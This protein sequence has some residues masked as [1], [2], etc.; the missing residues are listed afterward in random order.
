MNQVII[1]SLLDVLAI[2]LVCLMTVRGYLRG[3]SGE[4]AQLVSLGVAFFLGI[5]YFTP[6]ANWMV[7]HTRLNLESARVVGFV[8]TVLSAFLVMHVL[9]RLLGVFMKIVFEDKFD[10]VGG[11]VAGFLR[12]CVLLIIVFLAMNLWPHPYLNRKFGTESVIGSFLMR[13]L[14]SLCSHAGAAEPLAAEE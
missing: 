4:L 6:I 7:I 12:G 11:L 3:L 9:R 13:S 8:A 14:S 2:S 5:R 1:P 10:R